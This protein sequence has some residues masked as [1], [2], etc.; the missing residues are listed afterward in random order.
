MSSRTLYYVVLTSLLISFTPSLHAQIQ[1]KKELINGTV[2]SLAD[3]ISLTG[4][5]ESLYIGYEQ[6]VSKQALRA[7]RM[8]SFCSKSELITLTGHPSAVVR[9]YVFDDVL[10]RCSEDTVFNILLNHLDDTAKVY[11]L[12][13]DEGGYEMVGDYFV[14]SWRDRYP[15]SGSDTQSNKGL[16]DKLNFLDSILLFHHHKLNAF[17]GD[18]L[19]LEPK[20]SYY[21]MIRQLAVGGNKEAIV[22]LAKFRKKPDIRLILSYE[23]T[24]LYYVFEGIENYPDSGFKSML[25]RYTKFLNTNFHSSDEIMYYNALAAYKDTWA[26]RILSVPIINFIPSKY[27]NPGLHDYLMPLIRNYNSIYAPLLSN[28]WLMGGVVSKESFNILWKS[29]SVSCVGLIFNSLEAKRIKMSEG[30]IDFFENSDENLNLINNFLSIAL[31]KDS[32]RAFQLIK[33]NLLTGD[34]HIFSI[35]S[36]VAAQHRD[37]VFIDPLIKRFS[38]DDNAYV[39]M[40]AAK[41][42]LSYHSRRINDLMLKEIQLHPK[43]GWGADELSELFKD[44]GLR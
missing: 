39:Y 43:S 11:E 3:S 25:N 18:L 33:Q 32:L 24:S 20:P 36:E 38:E 12:E 27:G 16:I 30:Y 41:S 34:V 28:L 21:P 26:V 40:A 6:S 37:S 22:A 5:Y 35:F 1:Y 13:G 9:C 4:Q 17:E 8:N 15:I 42:L 19:L 29:D 10:W 44:N 31:E 7:A 23:K 2:D 14:R